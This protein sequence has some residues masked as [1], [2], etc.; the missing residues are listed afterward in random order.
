[1][2]LKDFLC[3]EHGIS[4]DYYCH[5]CNRKGI[6]KMMPGQDVIEDMLAR[7]NKLENNDDV[8]IKHIDMS[9]DGF[10]E[11]LKKLEERTSSTEG[12][13]NYVPSFDA[14]NDL[15]NKFYSLIKKQDLSIKELEKYQGIQRQPWQCPACFGWGFKTDTQSNEK[16]DCKGCEQKGYIWG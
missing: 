1:M 16:H 14:I 6:P 3:C 10:N 8:L 11:R 2:I 7:I 13:L 5:A 15:D 4:I 9:I 12:D